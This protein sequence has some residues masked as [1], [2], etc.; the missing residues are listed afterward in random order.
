MGIDGETI[1]FP[2]FCKFFFSRSVPSYF[3]IMP[4]EKHGDI[5]LSGKKFTKFFTCFG[6]KLFCERQF[7]HVMQRKS[8]QNAEPFFI[9]HERNVKFIAQ[10]ACRMW[11]ERQKA[12][13]GIC[14]HV[15]TVIGNKLL[16]FFKKLFTIGGRRGKLY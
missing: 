11:F 4:D 12:G 16:M 10:H 13:N 2:K 3:E 7:F 6:G 8:V 15:Q 9:R 14:L 5:V 1:L